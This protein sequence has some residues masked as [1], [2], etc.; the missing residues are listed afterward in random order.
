M[1]TLSGKD[2]YL[3]DRWPGAAKFNIGAPVNGYD[4]TKEG[5]GNCVSTAAFDIGEKRALYNDSTKHPGYTIFQYLQFVEGSDNAYD[6]DA[7]LSTGYG[8][9][10]H[11]NDAS[12]HSPDGQTD[13][14]LV[15]TDLTN[16]D[17][18]LGGAVAI[19]M[20]DFSGNSTSAQ[21][22]F[23]WF[24]VGGVCPCNTLTDSGGTC[25]TKAAGEIKTVGNVAIGRD[26]FVEDDGTNSGS[27]ELFDQTLVTDNTT[28][29]TITMA[30]GHAL[31]TDA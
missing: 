3:Y 23:G 6:A 21:N 22:E 7:D 1:A 20:A 4:S 25:Y 29:F 17:G 15:T 8:L 9:C 26:V 12:Q 16:S 31:A 28:E 11:I 30:V 24:W 27:L 19:A 18:T 5:S 13:W 10:F 14:Y 2:L